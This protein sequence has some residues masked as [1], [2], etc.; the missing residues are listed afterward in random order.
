MYSVN[1]CMACGETKRT[2]IAEYNRFIFMQSMWQSDMARFDYALCHGCGLVYATRR[3]NRAEYD[4]LYQNFNEFLMRRNNPNTLSVSELTAEKA[5]EIDRQFVPWWELKSASAK[6]AIRKVLRR[7]L[8][9]A[10]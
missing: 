6:G 3:P 10:L 7:D 1:A 4:F 2:I 5:S 9:N 8:D